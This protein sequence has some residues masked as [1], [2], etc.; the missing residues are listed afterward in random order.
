MSDLTICLVQVNQFW[1]D[2]KKNKD[3]LYQLIQNSKIE[4]GDLLILPEMFNTGF[5]IEAESNAEPWKNSESVNWLIELSDQF[6]VAIATS[7]IIEDGGHYYNRHVFISEK[8]VLGFYDKNYLFSLAGEDKKFTAGN[9]TIMIEY[10]GWRILPLTCYDLRFPEL[11]RISNNPEKHY[12]LIIYVANWPEKRIN[13][14]DKLLVSRAIENLTYVAGVNRIG[15]DGN[16]LNYNGHS[17]IID[18]LGNVVLSAEENKESMYRYVLN[19]KNTE[20]SRSRFGFLNDIK[21]S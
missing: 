9:S 13:H 3:H 6:K 17:Q 16:G 12:E 11:S 15:I 2:K 7:L 19:K 5:T 1:E 4:E 8:Q 21:Q 10:R 14:W 18:P 20:S